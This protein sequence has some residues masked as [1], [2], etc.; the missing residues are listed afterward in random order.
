MVYIAQALTRSHILQTAVAVQG[1]GQDLTAEE[2]LGESLRQHLQG[3]QPNVTK[4]I[5]GL[6]QLFIVS[7]SELAQCRL[8]TWLMP[9][10]RERGRS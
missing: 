10:A 8:T 3:L 4:V 2:Y 6:P 9:E 5:P 7:F 1:Q